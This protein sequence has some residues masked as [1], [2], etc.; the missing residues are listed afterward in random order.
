MINIPLV[1]VSQEVKFPCT[2][3]MLYAFDVDGKK[4]KK[5]RMT[6]TLVFFFMV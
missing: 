5:D 1:I 2:L 3:F 4:N 6:A